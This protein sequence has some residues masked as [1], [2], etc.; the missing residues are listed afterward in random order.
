MSEI[1]C[2]SGV[3]AVIDWMVEDWERVVPG[4]RTTGTGAGTSRWNCRL[5]VTV[6]GSGCGVVALVRRRQPCRRGRICWVRTLIQIGW[7]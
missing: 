1:M 4:C 5:A 6:A 2:S 3:V 7:P